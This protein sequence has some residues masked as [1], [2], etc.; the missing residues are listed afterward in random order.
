[1]KIYLPEYNEKS[2]EFDSPYSWENEKKKS[3]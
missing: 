2:Y 3:S 1:M